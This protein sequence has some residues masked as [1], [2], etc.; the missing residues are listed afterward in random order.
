MFYTDQTSLLVFPFLESVITGR[1]FADTEVSN[2][3]SNEGYNV[4]CSLTPILDKNVMSMIK[5]PWI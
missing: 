5:V 2:E 1:F 4:I 3:I